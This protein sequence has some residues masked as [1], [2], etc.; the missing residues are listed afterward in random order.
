MVQLARCWRRLSPRLHDADDLPL[1]IVWFAA[2]A[3]VLYLIW[4]C[5]YPPFI[6]A[7]NVAYSGEVMHDLWRGG[8]VYGKWYAFRPGVISHTVFYRLYHWLRFLFTP[9]VCIKI[10]SSA[11]VLG[12]P[13]AM[14]PLLR[15]LNRSPWLCL[16]A[17][18]LAF[19]TNLNMGYLPF[20]IGI[21][22]IPLALTLIESIAERP[23]LWRWGLLLILL[24]A[25]LWFH[26]FLTAILL[27]LAAL[28][29]ILALKGRSRLWIPGATLGAV[30]L[31][32]FASIRHGSVPRLHDVFQWITFSERWDQLDRDVL[33]WTLDGAAALSFPW[34]LLAFVASLV[35]MQRTP[36]AERGLRASRGA[37]VAA[38]LFLG[39]LLGPTYISWPEP[40][41]GFG[42]RIGI[43]F[44]LALLLVPTTSAIGWQ[45]FLQSSPWLAFTVWHLVAL[46]GPFQAFDAVVRPLAEL[47]SSLPAHSKIL[48]IS[49]SE[50]LKDPEHFAFGGFTGFVFRHTGKWL[51]V[52]TQG[53]QPW[54]FCDVGYHPIQCTSR[55]RA[56][57]RQNISMVSQETLDPYDYLL[58]L[59]NAPIVNEHLRELSLVLIRRQGPWSIWRPQSPKPTVAHP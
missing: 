41:W 19:N 40:A 43:T 14:R 20:V 59:D 13:L 12:L 25:S 48:P 23:R 42:T 49:G 10:L 30:I 38:A 56:P 33:Q 15:R 57:R 47:S 32:V 34:L 7:A 36:V 29:S 22:L 16:P 51:A 54:S 35:L 50:W 55:L 3:Y 8:A 58:V 21:P 2:S 6:D 27:P 46:T 17:F 31:V 39:Y 1:T 53:Y 24:V 44:A 18:A 45:R 37:I 52:E 9:I 5:A 4:V 26:F 11:G 28:W